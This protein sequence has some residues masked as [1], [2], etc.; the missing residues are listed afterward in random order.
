MRNKY[1]RRR[2]L[3]RTGQTIAVGAI[4]FPFLSFGR[5]D[6]NPAGKFG[7][8]V[9][10]PAGS[11]GPKIGER[12][13]ADGG[14]AVDAAVAAALAACVGSPHL[15]GVGGYGGHMML[16]MAGGK[17]ITCLDFNTVA[18]AAARPDMYPFDENGEVKG[19]ANRYGWLASG[20]P[21][22]L[23]G[24][25]LALDKHGTRSFRELV[26][27]AVELARNGTAM[28]GVCANT[29]HNSAARLRADPG[30]AKLYLTNGD[31]PKAGDLLRN[32][33]LAEMLS[34]LAQRNSVDSFYRGDI[35]QIIA[36]AFQKHG[37]LVTLRDLAAYHAREVKPLKWKGNGFEVLTAPL[38]AGGLTALETLSV[39]K[40]L[41]WKD[42]AA[43]P[44]KTHALLEALRLAW[45]DR[46]ELLGDPEMVKVPVKRLLSSDHAREL[47]A[48]AD[49][50]AQ[51]GKALELKVET[52]NGPGTTNISSVDRQGN[53][54]AVTLTH[55]GGFGAQVTVEGLGVTLGQ[56][57]YKFNPHPA[58]P[59]APGPG[60]RPLHNMCPTVILGQDKTTV[61]V[62]GA[63][64]QMI[65]NALL[66]FLISY[67][68]QKGSMSQALAVPRIHTTGTLDVNVEADWPPADTEHLTQAGFNV[69]AAPSAKLSAVSLHAGTGEYGSGLR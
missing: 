22:T 26:Q 40:A 34:T 39:L 46:L 33:D 66:G 28:D 48:Q 11:I 32:P 68:L 35:A 61:A 9:G 44:L 52:S 43:S 62:G 7:A 42:R 65:P 31:S 63:G 1:S 51:A 2:M 67:V 56:G 16:A 4:V 8:V 13:L 55:G 58:N 29:I 18:A 15:C 5:A 10:N 57:M 20:V 45:K 23:A 19:D 24:L 38:T 47:A 53:V 49:H 6:S 25:Q 41:K 60:K 59:N 54:V 64:G 30:S 3:V 37:G 36:G 27:P 12:I 21:G 17:H 50:A 69:R 14:N